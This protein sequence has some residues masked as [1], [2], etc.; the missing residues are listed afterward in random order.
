MGRPSDIDDT[1]RAIAGASRKTC[2]RTLHGRSRL[3]GDALRGDGRERWR[4]ARTSVGLLESHPVDPRRSPERRV[5]LLNRCRRSIRPAKTRRERDDA[6]PI[7]ILVFT[8][9]VPRVEAGMPGSRRAKKSGEPCL[10]VAPWPRSRRRAFSFSRPRARRVFTVLAP[11]RFSVVWR[12]R[13]AA[14]LRSSAGGSPS[15]RLVER[16]HRVE[17]RALNGDRID[18]FV[19]DALASGRAAAA[20]ARCAVARAAI[21]RAKLRTTAPEPAPKR[22]DGPGGCSSAANE[23]LLHEDRRR[24]RSATRLRASE[25]IQPAW[26]RTLRVW[27]IRAEAW[28]TRSNA[29][30]GESTSLCNRKCLS[31]ARFAQDRRQE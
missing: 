29:G 3:R 16:E 26:A 13:A 31:A 12:S 6:D 9:R 4:Q 23:G 21:C 14:G 11:A 27:E 10:P 18:G 30:V 1:P 15:D 28:L 2:G 8:R 7:L 24:L 20:L 22:V 17:E 5:E 19:H 25:R